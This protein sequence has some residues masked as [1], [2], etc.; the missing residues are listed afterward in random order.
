[1]TLG[2]LVTRIE[3]EWDYESVDEHGDIIDHNFFD[4]CPGIPIEPNVELVLVRNEL[5]GWCDDFQQTCDLK[6]RAWAYVKDG[7]LPYEFD[8]G[9]RVPR[10]FHRDLTKA[11]AEQTGE[12][13]V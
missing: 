3:Y 12:H 13:H 1:M 5:K 7:K 10:Q 6:H 9:Y 2:R 8:D 4:E 11:I